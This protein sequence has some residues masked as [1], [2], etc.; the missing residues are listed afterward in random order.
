MCGTVIGHLPDTGKYLKRARVGEKEEGQEGERG[1]GQRDR[2]IEGQK[3]RWI[4]GQKDRGWG[5]R[6]R[7]GIF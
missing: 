4:E 1:K 2:R 5:K 3:D 7:K 6:R